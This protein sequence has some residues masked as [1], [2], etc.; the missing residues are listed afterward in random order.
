[1]EIVSTGNEDQGLGKSPPLSRSRQ[2]SRFAESEYMEYKG[3]CLNQLPA[4]GV[5]HLRRHYRKQFMA[6]TGHL[7]R[8]EGR[9]QPTL[10]L[11]IWD[12]RWYSLLICGLQI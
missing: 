12:C 7:A 11:L 1:M 9:M 2:V 8:L 3:K 10:W 5:L 6:S 4:N